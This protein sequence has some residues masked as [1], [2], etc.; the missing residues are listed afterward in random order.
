[1]NYNLLHNIIGYR[2]SAYLFIDYSLYRYLNSCAYI[3]LIKL[4]AWKYFLSSR[5]WFVAS[6][7]PNSPIYICERT[8]RIYLCIYNDL[9]LY[10]PTRVVLQILLCHCSSCCDNILYNWPTIQNK[11]IPSFTTKADRPIYYSDYTIDCGWV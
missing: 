9:W 3:V 1:M 5:G 11:A 8:T 6:T 4:A 10:W 2:S 7:L